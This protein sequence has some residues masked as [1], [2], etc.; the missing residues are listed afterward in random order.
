MKFPWAEIDRAQAES[1]TTGFIKLV[2][3]GK[4][5]ELVGAHMIGAHAGELLGELALAMRHHLGLNDILKTIHAYPTMNTGIQQAAFEGYLEGTAA[6]SNSKIVH[7]VLN[8]RR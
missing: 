5:V 7:T 4:K 8:L 6:A 2:L 1:E 3:A